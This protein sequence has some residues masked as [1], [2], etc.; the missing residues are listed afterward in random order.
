ML[1]RP[2]LRFGRDLRGVSA[3]EFAL[4]A[5]PVIAMLLAG[6]DVTRYCMAVRAVERATAS[7]VQMV[8]VNTLGTASVDEIHFYESSAFAAFPGLLTDSKRAG[9]AWDADMALAVSSVTLTQP[10][11]GAATAALGWSVGPNRRTCGQLFAAADTASPS[12]TTLA[13]SAFGT[14]SI[15]VVDSRFTFV[16]LVAAQLLPPLVIART[17]YARPRY[18]PTI[19]LTGGAADV[20]QC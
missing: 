14:G 17:S 12:K 6:V 7:I 2:L 20:T 19:A 3:M 18:V 15:L 1:S 10:S 5:P 4:C 8:S 9:V 16:P 11:G 13:A